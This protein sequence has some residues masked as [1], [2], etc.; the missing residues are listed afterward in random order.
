M[1]RYLPYRVWSDSGAKLHFYTGSVFTCFSCF[2]VWMFTIN[3]TYITLDTFGTKHKNEREIIREFIIILYIMLNVIIC[4][5]CSTVFPWWNPL[6]KR[7]KGKVFDSLMEYLH[8]TAQITYLQAANAS[9]LPRLLY[10]M[11]EFFH[12]TAMLKTGTPYW[13]SLNRHNDLMIWIEI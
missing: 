10:L 7:T 6:K 5:R 12:V 9:H 2:A 8:H 4:L 13:K 11:I 3:V 1:D